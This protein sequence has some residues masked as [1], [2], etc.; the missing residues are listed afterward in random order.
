MQ[1]YREAVDHHEVKRRTAS[2]LGPILR[3]ALSEPSPTTPGLTRAEAIVA[4]QLSQAEDGKFPPFKEILL[5]V[6]GKAPA[7]PRR[8]KRA[9][10]PVVDLATLNEHQLAAYRTWL[11]TMDLPDDSATSPPAG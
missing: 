9:A 11:G 8:I 1:I 2:S 3:R 10:D 7:K 4:A 5:R 6:D